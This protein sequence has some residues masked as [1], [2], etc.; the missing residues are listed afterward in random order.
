MLFIYL[1]VYIIFNSNSNSIFNE[2]GY[3]RITSLISI[4][5]AILTFNTY[6]WDSIDSG[7]AIF[8]GLF[9]ITYFSQLLETFLF[10]I[11][12]II[13]IAWPLFNNKNYISGLLNKNIDITPKYLFIKRFNSQIT[14]YSLIVIFN[15]LGASFLIS[16]LDLISLYLSIELQSFALYVIST[17]F[18]NSQY[19][20]SAGLKYFLLGGLSSCFILFGS[21]LIYSFLG[22]T[23]IESLYGIMSSSIFNPIY[24]GFFFGLIAIY[25]G[26]LFK[27]SAAPLHNWAPD[28]YE[29]TPTIVTIW[30]TLIPK[31]SILILLVELFLGFNFDYNFNIIDNNNLNLFNFYNINFNINFFTQNV[32][33]MSSFLSLVIGS[34]VGLAQLRLKR[35]LSYSTINHIGFILLALAITSQK[36]LESFTFYFSQYIFT[37]LNVFLIIIL[38]SYFV[39]EMITYTLTKNE[40][41]S[42]YN[43]KFDSKP[44]ILENL[45]FK[46]IKYISE[47]KSLFFSNPLIAISF[48]ICLFS[49]AGIPPLMG[50]FSK[51]Y[52]LFSAVQKN[53]IFLSFICIIVSVISAY[54]YLK[55]ISF[56]YSRSTG[57]E[58]KLPFELSNLKIFPIEFEIK[59]FNNSHP[60]AIAIL[61]LFI[62]FFIFKPTLIL[63]STQLLS[64]KY[65]F[66]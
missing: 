36:S 62:L 35:L 20:T 63:S 16:S 22:I 47:L 56:I 64:L 59:I 6:Y 43:S 2:I 45:Y 33:L 5:C 21:A 61:T 26:L 65:F 37:N 60:Y 32:L 9:H 25:V 24:Y 66:M 52:V 58:A 14:N 49:M 44:V 34:A 8:G 54:Y 15:L 3:Y 7:L 55:V 29:D 50:F 19:S 42:N 39:K 57:N 46:D 1:L 28:V 30:L 41:K 4:F 40:Y 38:I 51:Y 53:Y 18:T 27:I 23:N 48:T 17:L 31:I 13:F 11:A 12:G 10:V